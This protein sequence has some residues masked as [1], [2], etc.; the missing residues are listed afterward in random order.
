MKCKLAEVKTSM[1]TESRN[2]ENQPLLITS[3]IDFDIFTLNN[4]QL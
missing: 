3:T 2:E 1:D 4:Y